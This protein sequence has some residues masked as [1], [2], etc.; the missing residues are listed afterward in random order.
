MLSFEGR[1]A[2]LFLVTTLVSCNPFCAASLSVAAKY[3][4]FIM[5]KI[6]FFLLWF[7]SNE[8]ILTYICVL[9]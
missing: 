9:S 8:S 2:L 5:G 1:L 3:C 4:K 6:V 7:L